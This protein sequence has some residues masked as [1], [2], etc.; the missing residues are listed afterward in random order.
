MEKPTLTV[1]EAAGY[2]G[3]GINAIYRLTWTKD[4]PAIRVGRKVLILR[5]GLDEW[6]RKA[7]R[8]EVVVGL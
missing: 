3:I 4:F 5:E 2:T 6:L 1:K 7:A 8:G